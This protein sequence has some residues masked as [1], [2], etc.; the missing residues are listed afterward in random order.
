MNYMNKL[1]NPY[2]VLGVTANAPQEVIRAAYRVMAKLHHP[3]LNQKSTNESSTMA[4]INQAYDILSCPKL[5][6]EY[7]K[8]RIQEENNIKFK[9]RVQHGGENFVCSKPALTTYDHR[10]RLHTYT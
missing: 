10:G 1:Q 8:R 9:Q 4:L 6:Y 2:E 3:D 7:D 5:R